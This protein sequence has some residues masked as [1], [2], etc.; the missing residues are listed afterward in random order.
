MAVEKQN[1]MTVYFNLSNIHCGRWPVKCSCH[2][3]GGQ[4]PP[5]KGGPGYRGDTHSSLRAAASSSVLGQFTGG[6]NC[7]CWFMQPSPFKLS[8]DCFFF[9]PPVLFLSV[10]ITW[11]S[12]SPPPPQMRVSGPRRVARKP[13]APRLELGALVPMM[14]QS[15]LRRNRSL[16]TRGGCGGHWRTPVRAWLWDGGPAGL[17]RWRWWRWC[18]TPSVRSCKCY[19]RSELSV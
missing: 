7:Q 5:N 9:F 2:D 15:F 18:V 16:R 6:K 12:P 4:R 1:W 13:D 11:L 14:V 8:W 3:S 10:Y 17:W 19:C